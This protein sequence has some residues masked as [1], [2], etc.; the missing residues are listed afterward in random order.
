ML[1]D[2]GDAFLKHLPFAR[3]QFHVLEH[4]INGSSGSIIRRRK[5]IY[6]DRE[7]R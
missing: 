3:V 7:P 5:T 1:S 4:A 6:V 2:V